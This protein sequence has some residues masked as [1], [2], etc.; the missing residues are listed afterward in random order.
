MRK[1]RKKA[2]EFDAPDLLAL[3]ERVT[4][5]GNNEIIEQLDITLATLNRYVP[6]FRRTR[7]ADYLGEIGLGA[8]ALYVMAKELGVRQGDLLPERPTRQVRPH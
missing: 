1:R 6:E 5:L 2:P 4:R 7:D 3:A 8:Q